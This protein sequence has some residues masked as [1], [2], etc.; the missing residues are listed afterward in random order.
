M[1]DSLL[2]NETAQSVSA[3]PRSSKFSPEEIFRRIDEVRR[4][5]D[6]EPSLL[7]QFLSPNARKRAAALQEAAIS[8]AKARQKLIDGLGDC[9]KTYI[10]AHRGDLK[11]RGGAFVL[12]TFAR[13]MKQLHVVAED[14][15]INYPETYSRSVSRID[16][17]TNLDDSQREQQKKLAWERANRGEAASRQRLD[18][19]LDEL[20]VQVERVVREIGD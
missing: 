14:L 7:E 17:L 19:A 3:T 5:L 1:N 20:G 18:A 8:A 2:N 4:G 10:D 9:I 16:A 12:E 6:T 15:Y 11:T 13:L